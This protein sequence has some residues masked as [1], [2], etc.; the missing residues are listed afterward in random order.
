[1]ENE[2]RNAFNSGA[3]RSQANR[4][5]GEVTV[6]IRSLIVASLLSSAA[7]AQ[8]APTED[9]YKAAIQILTQQRDAANNQVVETA[10]SLARVQREIAKMT[11]DA[12]KKPKTDAPN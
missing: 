5:R 10:V 1:M 3:G 9:D 7:F 2:I 4:I 12:A 11:A 8:T 6:L